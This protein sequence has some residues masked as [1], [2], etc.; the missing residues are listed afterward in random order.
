MEVLTERLL[1]EVRDE[2]QDGALLACTDAID[3][4]RRELGVWVTGPRG[5]A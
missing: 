3:N 2:L 5:E 4:L 1:A